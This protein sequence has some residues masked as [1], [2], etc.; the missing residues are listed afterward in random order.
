MPAALHYLGRDHIFKTTILKNNNDLV[1]KGGGDPDF[2]IE[3]LDSL[4]RT[5]AEIVED[6]NTLYLD[7]TL[8]DS[9]QYGNG[10]MWDEG[11]WWYAAPI[12]RYLLMIIALIFI[13]KP[14]KLGQPAI[15]DHFPKTEYISRLNKTTTVD[16]NVELKKLKIERDWVGRTNHFLM[17]GEIAI[18]DSSD[19]LQRNIHDPT[20]FT[21]TLF[22]ESLGKYGVQVDQIKIGT[23]NDELEPNS[24]P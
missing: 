20:L 22:K 8:L 14:G 12:G 18:S 7:A 4:A 24:D 21:G 23:K 19:T 10:W 11:S 17:T 16:S 2:S 15:I 5:T 6:V 9:M 1:L 3:Q 13:V